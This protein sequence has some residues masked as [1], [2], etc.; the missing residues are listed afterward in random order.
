MCGSAEQGTVESLKQTD[1]AITNMHYYC[2]QYAITETCGSISA[3]NK[4]KIK[5][6]LTADWGRDKV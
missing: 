1:A 3:N 4:L 6:K 2:Y 5:I